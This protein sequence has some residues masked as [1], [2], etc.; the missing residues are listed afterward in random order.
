MVRRGP[1]HRVPPSDLHVGPQALLAQPGQ[2]DVGG[3]G[4]GDHGLRQLHRDPG[5]G[6]RGLLLQQLRGGVQQELG[7]G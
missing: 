3:A 4:A 6:D 7:E 2:G 1:E 5:Q